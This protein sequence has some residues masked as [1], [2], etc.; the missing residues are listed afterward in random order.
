MTVSLSIF[1]LHLFARIQLIINPYSPMLSSALFFIFLLKQP[2][3]CLLSPLKKTMPV[4]PAV[5]SLN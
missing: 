4:I 5:N 1:E 3:V 2:F